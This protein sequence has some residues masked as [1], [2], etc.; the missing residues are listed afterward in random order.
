MAKKESI[1]D[2]AT[3]RGISHG[4]VFLQRKRPDLIDKIGKV[5]P[6]LPD[7]FRGK[8]FPV[9]YAWRWSNDEKHA[10]IG[11]CEAIS[12][13]ESRMVTTYHPTDDPVLIGF[14]PCPDRSEAKHTETYF[15]C[16]FKRTRPDREWVEIDETFNEKIEKLFISDPNLL[17]LI[18]DEVKVVRC[19]GTAEI[20]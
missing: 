13:L 7:E 10:K 6:N 14:L 4:K 19:I 5:I 8:D 11:T 15:L 17:S 16:I 18:F 1:R 20:I 12:K 9:V 3:R 2:E